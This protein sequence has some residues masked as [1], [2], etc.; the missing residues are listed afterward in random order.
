MRAR[1][2]PVINGGNAGPGRPRLLELMPRLEWGS[3]RCQEGD[4][5]RNQDQLCEQ[6]F[7]EAA[8]L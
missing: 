6:P 7:Q 4:V 2:C 5:S 3:G 8:V 1:R